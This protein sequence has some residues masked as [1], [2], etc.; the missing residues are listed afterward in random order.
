M[1]NTKELRLEIYKEV[2][3]QILETNYP[4]EGICNEIEYLFVKHPDSAYRLVNQ[5]QKELK[6]K[7]GI[8][9]GPEKRNAVMQFLF[10]HKLY[11]YDII[12]PAH[13]VQEDNFDIPFLK[14]KKSLEDFPELWEK[15]VFSKTTRNYAWWF[16][17]VKQR[18]K[19]MEKVITRMEKNM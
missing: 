7:F 12:K 5:I 13:Y 8:L 9:H 11:P 2:L 3:A 10:E 4:I 15:Y 19:F 1:K 17:S 18:A 6:E 14:E 16:D